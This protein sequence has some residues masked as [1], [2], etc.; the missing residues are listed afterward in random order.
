MGK[1][2]KY[3]RIAKRIMGECVKN[4]RGCR[5]GT[6]KVY[7]ECYALSDK[8]S[9][10]GTFIYIVNSRNLRLAEQTIKGGLDCEEVDRRFQ[11]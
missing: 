11:S 5:P 10:K 4:V 3:K 7:R 6:C 9:P 8:E 2:K 1:N